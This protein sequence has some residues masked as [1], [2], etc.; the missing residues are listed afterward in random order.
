MV[1]IILINF[2]L[3][4]ALFASSSLDK[5]SI[6]EVSLKEVSLEKV[7]LQLKWKYQFQFAGFIM[8]KEKGFYEDVGLDVKLLE[9]NNSVEMLKELESGKTDFAISDSSLIFELMKGRQ[10][11]VMLAIFQQSPFVLMGLKDKS[12]IS[13]NDL[14]NKRIAINA[15]SNA[16]TMLSM[17]H[18]HNI[19]YEKI[20]PVYTLDKMI[21]KKV[22]FISGYISNEPFIAKEMGLDITIFNPSDYGLE[23]YGDILFTL[24]ST[25]ERRPE[26]VEKMY[27]A[28]KKG[29]EYAFTHIDETV[30][31]IH[32]N[33]NTSLKKSKNALLYEAD[34]LKGISG[35]GKNFGEIK[36]S[37]VKNISQLFAF[38]DKGKYNVSEMENFIYQPKSV[39]DATIKPIALKKNEKLYLKDK[40]HLTLCTQQDFYPYFTYNKKNSFGLAIDFLNIISKKIKTPIKIKKISIDIERGKIVTLPSCDLIALAANIPHHKKLKTIPT[41]PYLHDNVVLVT[42]SNTPF[43]ENLKN[44]NKQKIGIPSYAK[45]LIRYVRKLYPN[46]NLVY[47]DHLNLQDVV[48]GKLF[49]YIGPSLL[50]TNKIA[51]EYFNELKIMNKIS[52]NKL[53][54]GFGISNS[55][56]ILYFILNK[57][58]DSISQEEKAHIK[59]RWMSVK[60][61]NH[62]D[63]KTI[64]NLTILFILILL[65]VS[66]VIFIQRKNNKKLQLHLDGTIEG[67]AI[68]KNKKL[69]D[70]NQQFLDIFHY[71]NIKEI[72]GK[73]AFFFADISSHENMKSKL[74]Q[75][76][77]QY[78]LTMIRKDGSTFPSILKGTDIGSATRMSSIIDISIL[79]NTQEKLETLNKSLAKKVKEEV[80]K[81][82]QQQALMF[83]Q[84]RLA[85]MGEMISMIAH[86]WRQPLNNLSILTQTL[87]YK[88]EKNKITDDIFKDFNT[89]TNIQIQGMS[90]TIDD[91]RN[92]FKPEKDKVDF[93]VNDVVLDAI[94]ML[95]PTLKNND[96]SVSF[97]SQ[98]EVI[99][100]GFPSELGQ[101]IINILNNAKD[102]LIENKIAIK[103]IEI[104]IEKDEKY[105]M[106]HIEDNAGG[107]ADKYINRVF[108]P[109]FSTKEEKNG[110]GLGLYMSKLIIKDHMNGDISV[111]NSE[112]GAKFTIVLNNHDMIKDNRK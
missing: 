18:L 79:K 87:S 27:E 111:N 78:E 63:K 6:E 93:N 98:E 21:D 24:K 50:L 51:K 16:L 84:S 105:T 15:N 41:N 59:N 76:S 91:F 29:W 35:Y 85:Q 1:K 28:S 103:T 110:T 36:V 46:I 60:T 31:M 13:I 101:V 86:Q 42:Q 62:I 47:H 66:V 48:D 56:H 32:K 90:R 67:I 57:A 33:Y 58:I 72:K 5:R 74:I 26:L 70:A 38:M 17:L 80:S 3:F 69:I 61:E 55:D 96:I 109:Y 39:T 88:Y 34:I 11:L 2:L 7:S 68:F 49:G 43:I 99:S 22:D 82:Q 65:T 104:T 9:M 83:H 81:N 44:L 54:I 102:I 75:E 94:E 92:F 8:A 10:L 30:E 95:N 23:S 97:K 45:G 14:Q 100:H 89:N 37:K 108:D 107:I 19:S 40:K 4:T 25:Q 112:K 20:S 53:A 64:F 12:I 106:M 71:E 77:I 52:K 73:T